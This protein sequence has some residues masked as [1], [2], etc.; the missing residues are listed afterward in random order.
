MIEDGWLTQDL[1]R[2]AIRAATSAASVLNTQPWLFEL[3]G[4]KIDLYGDSGRQLEVADPDGRQLVMSCGAALLNLR[5][6][7]L[8][9][10]W[11]PSVEVLPRL[12]EPL[13]IAT[14][15]LGRA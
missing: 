13:H 8:D 2:K 1:A 11:E 7:L 15:G 12:G 9:S 10:G 6:A 14:I 5:L 4:D 3:R